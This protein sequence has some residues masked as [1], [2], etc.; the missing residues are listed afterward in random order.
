MRADQIPLS[1]GAFVRMTE[2]GLDVPAVLTHAGLSLDLMG[3][4]RPVVTTAQFFAFWHAVGAVC[5]DPSLGLKLGDGTRH[6][7]YDIVTAAALHACTLGEALDKLARYKRLTCPEDVVVELTR[8]EAAVS[9]RWMLGEGHTPPLLVDAI[10]ASN[11]ALAERGTGRPVH[12]RRI[13]LTRRPADGDLLQ[14][15]FRCE[16]RFNAPQD[17]IVYQRS[18]LELPFVTHDDGYLND[19]LPMLEGSLREQTAATPLRDRVWNVL[20]RGMRGGHLRMA[21]V[22]DTLHLSTRTLQRRLGE[23]DTS[24]QQVLDQVRRHL[25]R[26]LLDATDLDT[27]E[28]AFLLG[29]E[30]LN[31]FNRAFRQWEG[32]TPTRWRS[33][34]P[35]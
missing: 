34:A 24:Y 23:A 30:E 16:L 1:R 13:E 19:L 18:D 9:T 29:F 3:M 5:R 7:V 12:L 10:F 6:E 32:D 11:L 20:A 22:A 2:I 25:A 14:A 28:I 15:H 33:A 35:G 31:S 4:P 26:R 17:R 21:Q 27:G 8:D